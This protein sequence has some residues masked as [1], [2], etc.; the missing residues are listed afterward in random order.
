MTLQR[1]T[2]RQG[3]T[4]IELLVVIAIIAILA[5]ILF[6]VFARARENARR[7]SCQSNLKQQGLA[8]AQ[9][10]QDYDERYPLAIIAESTTPAPPGGEWSVGFWFWPQLTFAY[11][12]STQVFFCPSSS[13][14]RTGDNAKDGYYGA[15]RLLLPL[16]A[17]TVALS[18]VQ[19]PAGT[20]LILD[21]SIYT[22][23]P[24]DATTPGSDYFIPGT[25]ELTTDPT[26]GVSAASQAKKKDYETGR[27]FDGVNV[28]YADGH[29][30]WL[31][32]DKVY[33]EAVKYNATTHPQSNWDPEANNS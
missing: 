31:K 5:A 1:K 27:H 30:K 22:T 8:I 14:P 15:N 24:S 28:A 2:N 25:D 17:P 19:S 16:G 18:S 3:F 10:T 20:F 26:F 33:A 13:Y 11:H 4:L 23:R 7:A 9:Y 21:A 29:V 6:P 32:S 12:K